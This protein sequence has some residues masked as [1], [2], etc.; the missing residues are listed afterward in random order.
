[1]SM[2]TIT[3]Q[4]INTFEAPGRKA[5]EKAGIEAQDAKPK[6]QLLGEMPVPGEQKRMELVTLTCEDQTEY[7]SFKGHTITVPI[8]VFAPSRGQ[9]I[10][11]IPKGAKP[12]LASSSLPSS[13][14]AFKSP[15][16]DEV[17]S[18]AVDKPKVP[19]E[20]S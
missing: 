9:I 15:I 3:G 14:S 5:N 8:G 17:Q 2:F 13:T 19:W 11:F 7:E 20:K 18:Q 12:V 4:V 10:Y 1:M 6:V 16:V